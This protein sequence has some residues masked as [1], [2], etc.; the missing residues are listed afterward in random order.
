MRHIL[1]NLVVVISLAVACSLVSC[2]RVPE[3]PNHFTPYN[4][5]IQG[6]E[7]LYPAFS[8]DG[9]Y[10]AYYHGIDT[11]KNYPSGLYIIDRD[12]ANRKLILPGQHI[13]P[14]WSP[15]GKWLVFSSHGVLQKCRISGDSLTTFTALNS[16][17]R[18]PDFFFPDWSK[19]GK[20][21]YFDNPFPSDGGGVYRV[22]ADFTNPTLVFGLDQTGYAIGRDPDISPDLT[23]IVFF[24]NAKDSDFSDIYVSDLMGSNKIRLTKNGRD[25]LNPCWSPDGQKIAWSSSVRI[26]TMNADGINQKE[27]TYGNSPSWSINNLIVFSHANS[28]YTKEVLFTINPD[29][30]SRKQITF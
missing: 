4:Y 28:N 13:D 27:V 10:I 11:T 30:T 20:Y 3:D 5:V 7:D 26:C 23:K 22:D 17:L 1:K 2:N 29:G 12:G 14:S 25:N 6:P 16:S 19:D 15:D 8:P 18:Y 9:N 24:S 21:I